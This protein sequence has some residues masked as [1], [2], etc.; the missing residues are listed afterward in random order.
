TL[1][2]FEYVARWAGED[3][4]KIR[5]YNLD[6]TREELWPWL[7]RRG[8]ATP[9]DVAELGPFLERVKKANRDVHLRPGL[10]LIRRWRHEDVEALGRGD[11]LAGALGGALG[12]TLEAL[13]A[14]PLPAAATLRQPDRTDTARHGLGMAAKD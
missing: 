12:R 8:Y 2:P 5:A 3:A 11:A 9:R 7:L 1:S 13:D 4:D 14:P 6:E 10:A